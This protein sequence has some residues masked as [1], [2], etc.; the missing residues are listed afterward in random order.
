MLAAAGCGNDT[1]AVGADERQLKA[2]EQA[3]SS[4]ENLG[5]KMVEKTYPQM[6]GHKAWAVNQPGGLR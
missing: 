5:S 6:P 2:Q 1:S 4:L 3:R